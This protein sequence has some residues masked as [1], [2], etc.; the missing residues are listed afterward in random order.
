MNTI[1]SNA[2]ELL[3]ERWAV[4]VDKDH[5]KWKEWS[6]WYIANLYTFIFFNDY[7][8]IGENCVKDIDFKC[9]ILSVS[10]FKQNK[11][12]C[13]IWTLDEFYSYF[14]T[15][16]AKQLHNC[17]DTPKVMKE[18]RQYTSEFIEELTKDIEARPMVTLTKEYES[19]YV[20]VESEN[21]SARI[22]ISIN[23]EKKRFS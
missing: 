6:E 18:A 2:L 12:L 7:Y 14:E 8:A 11:S 1:P 5:P 3:P 4:K 15:D 22:D 16:L 21:A 13:P 19:A 10:E 23:W 17:Y 9:H 20:L